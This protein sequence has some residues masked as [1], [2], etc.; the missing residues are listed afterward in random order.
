MDSHH[1]QVTKSEWNNR[2]RDIIHIT[3]VGGSSNYDRVHITSAVVTMT[4]F[5]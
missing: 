4:A 5:T 3:F 2:L 1:M